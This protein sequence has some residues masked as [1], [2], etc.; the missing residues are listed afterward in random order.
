[1]TATERM[2]IVAYKPFPGKEKA[3]EILLRTH[4]ETLRSQGLASN[5][6]PVFLKAKGAYIE[7][8][9]WKSKAAIEAAHQMPSF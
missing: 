8:F 5:R 4:V 3:L 7:I 6:K 1:M 2:V 9:G